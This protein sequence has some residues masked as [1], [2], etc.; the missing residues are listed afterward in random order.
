MR[1]NPNGGL[2]SFNGHNSLK[3]DRIMLVVVSFEM[4][5]QNLMLWVLFVIGDYFLRKTGADAILRY[6]IEQFTLF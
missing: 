5:C 6:V 2:L 3:I 1:K 4:T